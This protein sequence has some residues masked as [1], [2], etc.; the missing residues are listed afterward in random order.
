MLTI[1]AASQVTHG[2]ESTCQCM[3]PKRCGFNPWVGKI[4]SRRKWQPTPV[5]LPGK[6]PE[7]GSQVS[8]TP[9]VHKS[10]KQLSY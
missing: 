2:K 6:P 5:S 7:Q 9:W 4:P 8:Y 1:L 3:G 10:W